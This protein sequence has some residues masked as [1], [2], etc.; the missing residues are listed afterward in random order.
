MQ[1][2]EAILYMC[3]IPECRCDHQRTMRGGRSPLMRGE[4]LSYLCPW[5]HHKLL[6]RYKR[7]IQVEFQSFQ[8]LMP[9]LLWATVADVD[10]VVTNI[11]S[12]HTTTTDDSNNVR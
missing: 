10:S 6:P 5:N 12:W 1:K 8:W 7:T 3:L 11:G 4:D 2:V 9:L